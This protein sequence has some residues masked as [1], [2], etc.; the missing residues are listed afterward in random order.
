MG[1]IIIYDFE[2]VTSNQRGWGQ[3]IQIGA[4]AVDEDLNELSRFNERCRLS[5]GIIPEAMAMIV[6]NTTPKL[7]KE[8]NR[9]HYEMIR[10]FVK[11]IKQFKNS[12]FMGW[13]NLE[14]DQLIL[15]FYTPGEP[16]SGWIHCSYTTD[17]PRKQFL[18]AYKSEGKTKYKPVIGKAKDLV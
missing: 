17:Q 6:S 16:N 13:N 11:W 8:S 4:I 5:P 3:I 9:S 12:T 10:S 14:F 18:H 1:N 15:E 7:L 2:T